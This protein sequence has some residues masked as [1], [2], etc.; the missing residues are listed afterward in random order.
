MWHTCCYYILIVCHVLPVLFVVRLCLTLLTDGMVMKKNEKKTTVLLVDDEPGNI[1]I[2]TETLYAQYTLQI[3]TSGKE[4]LERVATQPL[5]DI[6]LLDIMMPE[7]DGFAVC[8]QLKKV[9]AT[10]E[11]PVIFLTASDSPVDEAKGFALGAVDYIHK[12]FSSPLVLARINTHLGL[13]EARKNLSDLLSRTT[14][15]SVRVL[16]EILGMTNSAAVGRS[17]RILE[18]TRSLAEQ[19][20]L[21]DR[22]KYEIAAMLSHIGC[23]GISPEA[24]EKYYA[25]QPLEED[26]K[27]LIKNHPAVGAELLSRIPRLEIVASIIKRQ[28]APYL[29][30]STDDP[31]YDA[32]IGGQILKAALFFDRHLR[33][34]LPP[35][36]IIQK[37]RTAQGNYSP[38][39]LSALEHIENNLEIEMVLEVVPVANVFVGMV[40]DED[41]RTSKGILLAPKG[42]E[43][44]RSLCTLLQRL[45]DTNP[46]TKPIRVQVPVNQ[47]GKEKEQ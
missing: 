1:K 20:E 27:K 39:I 35:K 9:K 47:P 25:D 36:G 10:R 34:G 22:W 32:I 4:A 17:S 18:L 40:L 15:G 16:S 5:P 19:L 21:K 45:A 13:V 11:I 28:Q 29:P 2:L 30:F 41:V 3:A 42:T 26:D 38:R 12:P 46:D 44:S 14:A 33:M 8:S 6:I 31:D 23:I 7:M 43:V 37:M 24:L